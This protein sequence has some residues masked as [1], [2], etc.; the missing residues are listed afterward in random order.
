MSDAVLWSSRIYDRLL[1]L[2]P[3]DLTRQYG[4]EM[5]L[6][7]AENVAAAQRREG[8]WGVVRVWRYALGEFVRLAAPGWRESHVVRVPAI[9]FAL[10]LAIMSLEMAH[11]HSRCAMTPAQAMCC[12][13]FLPCMTTPFFAAASIWACRGNR[14]ISLGL[15]GGCV[16][17]GGRR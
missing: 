15:G 2:Y 9:W 4:A 7:F 5:A 13:L 11:S 12:A 1:L 8:A 3:E 17:A 10:S 16:P 14:V 6:V